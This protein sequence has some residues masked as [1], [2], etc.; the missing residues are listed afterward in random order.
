MI[1]TLTLISRILGFFRDQRITQLV[2]TSLSGDAYYLAYRI[3]N[4]L[5]RL[6]G[7]G[8][9]SAAF[10]PVLATYLTEKERDDVWDFAN[11]M[12]WTLSFLLAMVAVL[13]V[14][15]SPALVALFTLGESRIPVD[16]AVYL[17]RLMFPY[18]FFIS[19]SALAG[20]L[21]N[22]FKVFGLPAFTP[23]MLNLSVIGFS[24]FADRFGD[25]TVA[26]ALGV[27]VGGV[28]QM[29]VQLP[30]L[31]KL[32][33]RFHFGISF[34]HPGIRRVAKLMVPGVVGISVAQINF[35][36]DTIFATQSFLPEG[37]LT[38]LQI[39]DRVMELVLGGYAISVGTAILPM[40][41]RHAAE[42]NIE[43]LKRTVS[44]AIRIVSFITVPAMVG[45]ILLREPI[46]EVLFQHGRF[47]AE[48][49]RLTAWALMLYSIGLP[50]FAATKIL[51]P[52]FYST[53]D[54]RTPVRVAILVMGLNI[55]LNILFIKPLL[56]GG[57]ALATSL[58]GV[59]NASLLFWIFRQRH[60]GFGGRQ[61][62]MSLVRVGVASVCMG[63]ITCGLSHWV[64]FA[65]LE[66][67]W[68]RAGK[69]GAILAASTAVY[70][71]LAWLLRCEELSDI[72]GIAR[73]KKGPPS[74][75]AIA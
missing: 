70:F 32:G 36:V 1:T 62:V 9:M 4:L 21:L 43:E 75:P 59:L 6:V 73:R 49:T 45:L 74:A 66:P 55:V 46:I 12:F 71:A 15:F 25:P 57:P 56:N 34:S 33:M 47:N 64:R 39:A 30:V 5:R 18:I 29:L 51:V 38:S 52:A 53:Q 72:Y 23:A 10:V 67:L 37:S 7:E 58:A 17:N 20:A 60:G 41:S 2:G 50:W 28:L 16:Q 65:S 44:F 31:W 48:S 26:L 54:T 42:K 3:P 22:S 63:L 27:L 14:V 24:L 40:M 35:F 69:L 8:S 13:G 19:I 68:L 11:R 61:I